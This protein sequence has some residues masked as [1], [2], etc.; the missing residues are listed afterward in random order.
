MKR[1]PSTTSKKAAAGA[2]STHSSPSGSRETVLVITIGTSPSVLTST[3][4]ALAHHE[5]ILPHRVKVLTTRLGR[6]LLMQHVFTPS[7]AFGGG[8]AWDALWLDLETQ[9]FD[10]AGRLEFSPAAIRIFTAI[11][12]GERLPRELDDITTQS[13]NEQV[14]DA[15]LETLRGVMN[16]D[17]RVIASIAGG[18]KTVSALFYACVS[19]IGR[20]DDRIVHVVINE[21]FERADLQPPFFFPSQQCA[22]LAG[23]GGQIVQAHDARLSV[24]EVPFVPLANLFPRELGR[25]PGRFSALVGEYRQAGQRHS[26]AEMR[27]VVYRGRSEIEVDGTTVGLPPREQLLMVFLAEHLLGGRS[28]FAS[29]QELTDALE[30]WRPQFAATR[31]ANDLGDWRSKLEGAPLDEQDVRRAISNLGAKLRKEG[32]PVSILGTV[33]PKRG[34]FALALK[35]TQVR[36]GE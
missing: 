26:L 9:G 31:P 17:S 11:T 27:V 22:R 13:E 21:P 23:R 36:L 12:P 20:G 4:W 28:A 18:R 19:L 8:T 30:R 14:A 33:L 24:I 25:T 6:E 2:A 29:V 35:K 15:M 32:P 10:L 16:D 3:I 34:H 1:R 5:G 7:P